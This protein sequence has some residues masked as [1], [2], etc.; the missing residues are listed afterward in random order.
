MPVIDEESYRMRKM[1]QALNKQSKEGHTQPV[2]F[3][4]PMGASMFLNEDED[5]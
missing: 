4:D 1:Q 5:L 3:L 2:Q